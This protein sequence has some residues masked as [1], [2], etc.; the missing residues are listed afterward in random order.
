MLPNKER[1]SYGFGPCKNCPKPS[2]RKPRRPGAAAYEG[3]VTI[4]D[5]GLASQR[6]IAIE[7]PL[8]A[9]AW[10]QQLIR[11]AEE[12]LNERSPQQNEKLALSNASSHRKLDS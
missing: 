9:I 1:I 10:A 11:E 12:Q 3:I 5:A 7:N 2:S 4:I 6:V 8:M